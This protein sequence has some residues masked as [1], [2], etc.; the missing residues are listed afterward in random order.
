[1]KIWDGGDNS[2]ITIQ[3]VPRSQ[4]I[5]SFALNHFTLQH[6]APTRY[7]GIRE[8]SSGQNALLKSAR[9]KVSQLSD[10]FGS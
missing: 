10:R 3:D 2:L 5:L 8:I 7:H 4:P 6:L 1:M 9:R